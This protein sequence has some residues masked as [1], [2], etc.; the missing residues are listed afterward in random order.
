[1]SSK[2]KYFISY[3]FPVVF[4]MAFIFYMSSLAGTS[5]GGPALFNIDKAYHIVEYFV[6]S[7]LLLRLMLHH[8]VKNPYLYAILLASMYGITDEFHQLFVPGRHFN[9]YDILA[10]VIGASLVLFKRWK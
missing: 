10:N 3:I 2:I 9:I 4:Y 6:L 5:M 1:M 8:N 7:L